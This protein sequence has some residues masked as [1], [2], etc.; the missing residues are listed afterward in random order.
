MSFNVRPWSRQPHTFLLSKTFGLDMAGLKQTVDLTAPN[1]DNFVDLAVTVYPI[2]TEYQE[3]WLKHKSLLESNTHGER[4]WFNSAK[5]NFWAGIQWLEAEEHAA[6]NTALPQHSPKLFTRDPV[7]CLLEVD[8]L[9]VDSAASAALHTPDWG[10]HAV[11]GAQNSVPSPLSSRKKASTPQTDIW[12]TRNQWSLGALWKKSAYTL[13][14]LWAPLKARYLHI[15]T[16]V[17]PPLK[18]K[19]PAYALQLLLG[20]FESKKARYFTH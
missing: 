15:T 1:A 8:K 20:P 16:T 4:L 2:H 12:S 6:F 3:E 14:L 18:V 19:Q 11:T 13:Q 9:C 5:T 7:I 17:G 10:V